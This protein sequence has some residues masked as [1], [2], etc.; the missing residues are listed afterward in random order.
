[1]ERDWHRY[2]IKFLEN[3]RRI[4]KPNGKIIGITPNRYSPWY[5]LIG[6]LVRK[7]TKHLSTDRYYTKKEL[8]EMLSDT[9]FTDCTIKYWGFVPPGDFP[10]TLSSILHKCENVAE[11]S[12]LRVLA[13]GLAIRAIKAKS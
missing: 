8:C 12:F 10:G 4:L 1:M 11:K 3:C 5:N 7:T 9:G 2:I 6:P 13:G